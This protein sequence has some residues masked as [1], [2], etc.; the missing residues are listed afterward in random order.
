MFRFWFVPLIFWIGFYVLLWNY[1]NWTWSKA[2]MAGI[3]LI[4]ALTAAALT[5]LAAYIVILID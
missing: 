4:C 1:K 2:K 3:S 5:A